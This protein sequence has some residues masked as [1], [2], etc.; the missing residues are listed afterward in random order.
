M[1]APEQLVPQWERRPANAEPVKNVRFSARFV[2]E[3]FP[4]KHQVFA[5]ITF[6]KSWWMRNDGETGWPAGT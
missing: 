1:S 4:A 2:K 5:G 6:C 3:S